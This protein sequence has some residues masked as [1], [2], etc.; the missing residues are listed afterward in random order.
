VGCVVLGRGSKHVVSPVLAVLG[1]MA[2]Y[3]YGTGSMMPVFSSQS[4]MD[5][6]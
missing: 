3:Y 1:K 2:G 4:G 5:I 6:A